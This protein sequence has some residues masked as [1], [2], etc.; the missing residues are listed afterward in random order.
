MEDRRLIE[1]YVV[2][3]AWKMYPNAVKIYAKGICGEQ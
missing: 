2:E 3:S 1:D